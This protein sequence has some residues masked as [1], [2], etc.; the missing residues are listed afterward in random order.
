MPKLTKKE[1]LFI[2]E[3]LKTKNATSAAKSAGYTAKRMDQQGYELLRKPEISKAVSKGLQT[4]ADNADVSAKR[5]IQEL[6]NIA[7]GH[8]GLVCIQSDDT[9]QLQLRRFNDMDVNH[10]GL[11]SAVQVIETHSKD[12]D[13]LGIKTNFKMHDKLKAL[14][15]LS[16]HLGLLNGETD[17]EG[18]NSE[19]ADRRLLEHVGKFRTRKRL[20]SSS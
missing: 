7:F 20:R 3:Y 17:P 4:L 6:A 11:I 19:N 10:I 18:S 9:G 5:V 12:G 14:E 1:S 2:K 15:L 8:L 13:V 16:K